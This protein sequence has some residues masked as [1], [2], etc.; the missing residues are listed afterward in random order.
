MPQDSVSQWEMLAEWLI[1]GL[2]FAQGPLP[3]IILKWSSDNISEVKGCI[4][5]NT[6]SSIKAWST[7]MANFHKPVLGHT[8][9]RRKAHLNLW[10]WHDL[11]RVPEWHIVG[12]SFANKVAITSLHPMLN[13]RVGEIFCKKQGYYKRAFSIWDFCISKNITS[14]VWHWLNVRPSAWRQILLFKLVLNNL[15]LGIGILVFFPRKHS[16]Q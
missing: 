10:P 4:T 14:W 12:P 6:R 2:H 9:I 16:H 8:H 11:K 7:R 5:K 15:I 3:A 13:S 1:R